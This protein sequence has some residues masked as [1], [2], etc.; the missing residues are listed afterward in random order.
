MVSRFGSY[1]ETR[2]HLSFL[3]ARKIG[4]VV[5]SNG[6][7]SQLTDVIAA[8]A[9]DLEAGR[10]DARDSVQARMDRLRKQLASAPASIRRQD[11]VR[12]ARQ[13]VPLNHP[14]ASFAGTYEA[15]GYGQMVITVEGGRARYQ[16]G[17][18]YGPVEIYDGTKYLATNRGGRLGQCVVIFVPGN[19][20]F[21]IAHALDY[22][23]VLRSLI[24]T[25]RL[26]SYRLSKRAKPDFLCGKPV[27]MENT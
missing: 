4:V 12:A 14:L 17:D 20:Q 23:P 9:Y 11:S 19:R 7:L 8:F 3:P 27:P 6:G 18:L 15:K 21:Y 5:M 1:G 22:V 2:S 13:R 24:K 10:A 16:W 26:S 25:R